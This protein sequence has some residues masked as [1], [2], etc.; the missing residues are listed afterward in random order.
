MINHDKWPFKDNSIDCIIN[1]LY[2]HN[3]DS[4]EELLRRYQ[5]TLVPDGC[6]L[7]NA[8]TYFSFNELKAVMAL[9]ESEREGGV[10]QNIISFPHMQEIGTLLTKTGFNLPSI[11]ITDNRLYF[12]DLVDIFDF[13]KAVGETN[14]LTNRRVYKSHET[15][16][17]AMAL[18]KSIFNKQREETDE[19]IDPLQRKLNKI[20]FTENVIDYIYLTLEITS[21]IS[22]KYDDSQQKPKERGSAEFNLKDLAMET[23]EK[24]EDPTIRIG[25]IKP[26]GEDYEIEELTDKIKAKIIQKIGKEKVDEKLESKNN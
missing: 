10:S 15:Y 11:S 20:K 7:G 14:F 8:Y 5:K 2:L 21:F 19:L 13:M 17:A 23:L 4:F 12:D 26:K 9:A 3:T 18:Y 6:L 1:N 16:I 24:N 25:T 22:W